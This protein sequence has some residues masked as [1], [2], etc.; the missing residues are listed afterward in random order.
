MYLYF[1]IKRPDYCVNLDTNDVY[2]L[3]LDDEGKIYGYKKLWQKLDNF[4]RWNP[5]SNWK[6]FEKTEKKPE[7]LKK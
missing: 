7:W 1:G 2:E 5:Y 6:E 3:K 4:L